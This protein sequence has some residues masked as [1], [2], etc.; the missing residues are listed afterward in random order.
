MFLL[1][2]DLFKGKCTKLKNTFHKLLHNLTYPSQTCHFY[3]IMLHFQKVTF[4]M[5]TSS[6][7]VK[8]WKMYCV[9]NK[10]PK[11]IPIWRGKII[12]NA[13]RPVLLFTSID[14]SFKH[15][16]VVCI[17]NQL[18]QIRVQTIAK[19]HPGSLQK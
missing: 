12:C 3:K 6:I 2:F 18:V 10:H 11:I 19:I 7:L 16:F 17:I 13:H 8:L 1:I 9:D 5:A 14:D 4:K 15:H